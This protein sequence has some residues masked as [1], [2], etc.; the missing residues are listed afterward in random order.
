[1]N[2][3]KLI[4]DME[5]LKNINNSHLNDVDLIN[6]FLKFVKKECLPCNGNGTSG[7]KCNFC[8]GYGYTCSPGI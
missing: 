8:N 2:G 3:L 5:N 6:N 4:F 1:M 7:I